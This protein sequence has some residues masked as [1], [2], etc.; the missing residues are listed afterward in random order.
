[1]AKIRK[2]KSEDFDFEAARKTELKRDLHPL[3]VD[4]NT[5]IYV[6]SDKCNEEYKQHYLKRLENGRR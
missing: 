2:N 4:V 3:R 5:V 1:M 6:T